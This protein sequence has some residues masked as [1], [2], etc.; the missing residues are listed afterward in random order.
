[1]SDRYVNSCPSGVISC[2]PRPV[3]P[4]S[5]ALGLK[6]VQMTQLY[7]RYHASIQTNVY[8]GLT[9]LLSRAWMQRAY[10]T[11]LRLELM[12]AQMKTVCLVLSNEE[13]I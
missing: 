4:K 13:N 11:Y 8:I 12:L 2:D 7:Q 6:P 10:D 3:T 5:E 1:M 9:L